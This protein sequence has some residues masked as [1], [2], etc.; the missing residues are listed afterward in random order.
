EGHQVAVVG[1]QNPRRG[2]R[3][4]HGRMY[5]P[6]SICSEGLSPVGYCTVTV[7]VIN[8]HI[9]RTTGNRH[10]KRVYH[11]YRTIAARAPGHYEYI[12]YSAWL[13]WRIS[14][15]GGGRCYSASRIRG[16]SVVGL[17]NYLI[18]Q[19]YDSGLPCNYSRICIRKINHQALG[20]NAWG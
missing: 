5:E 20:Y 18:I 1:R 16:H 19:P 11:P 3:Y 17:N 7:Y 15:A 14:D 9:G 10:V 8:F 13:K 6:V 12:I 2:I 4:G